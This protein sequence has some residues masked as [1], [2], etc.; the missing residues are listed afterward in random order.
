MASGVPAGGA[1]EHHVKKKQ[2]SLKEF[3]GV[4]R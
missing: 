3:R 4:L 1:T 2:D